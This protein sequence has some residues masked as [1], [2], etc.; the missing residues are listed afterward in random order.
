M[1]QPF[2]IIF[3]VTLLTGCSKSNP[4]SSSSGSGAPPA[5]TPGAA[6][7]SKVSL[8]TP[9]QNDVCLSG[10]VVSDS[11]STVSFSWTAGSNTT[12]YDLTIKNLLST[13]VSTQ[14]TSKTQLDV[15][16][17][18][19]TPF[20]W[21]IVSKSN[22]T[23][24]TTQSDTWKFYNAGNGTVS[25][26]PYPADI[27]TP[28]YGQIFTNVTSAVNL[29]WKGSS[30][31]SG[32]IINFDIYSGTTKTPGLLKSNVTDSFLNNVSVSSGSTYYWKV[33]SRDNAGNTTDS[34]LNTFTVN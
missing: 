31:L 25:Y 11:L 23:T 9:D 17:P 12:E 14:A 8:S 33:T 21:Y 34:E 27:L 4:G 22:A 24:A 5:T 30:V 13:Q 10:T 26:P 16:L 28:T 1:K 32:T 19:N 18:R 7:P 3:W 2:I 29:T 20:S 6:A 15:T